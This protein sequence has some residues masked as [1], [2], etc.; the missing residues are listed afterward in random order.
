MKLDSPVSKIQRNDILI[1]QRP[2]YGSLSLVN[3]ANILP[4]KKRL[5]EALL[6]AVINGRLGR[7]G[8][9]CIDLIK[10]S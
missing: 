10:K 1:C 3:E 9:M 6:V 5:P 7:R 4:R 8:Q 2:Q